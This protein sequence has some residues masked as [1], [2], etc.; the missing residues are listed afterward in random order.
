MFPFAG[1]KKITFTANQYTGLLM[2]NIIYSDVINTKSLQNNEPSKKALSWSDTLTLLNRIDLQGLTKLMLQT[3]GKIYEY[4]MVNL[5]NRKYDRQCV[6]FVDP[7][8][9][10]L[11]R[12]VSVDERRIQGLTFLKVLCDYL[13]EIKSNQTARREL[14]ELI[15]KALV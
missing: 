15:N 7:K 9:P 3:S 8:H 4:V 6:I 14:K 10:Y 5:K 2:L 12:K 1:Q 11:S 13:N